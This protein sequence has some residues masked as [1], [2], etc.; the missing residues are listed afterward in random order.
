MR[1]AADYRVSSIGPSTQGLRSWLTDG[2]NN[3]G[4]NVVFGTLLS[5]GFSET[6]LAELGGRVV[7]LTEAAEET[8]S[9]G[10]VDHT[11]E[12]LFPEVR[13]RGSSAL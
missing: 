5:Q 9:G 7:G 1:L 12:L 2:S 10:G 11:A 4:N 8:S 6:D 3:V 13:P